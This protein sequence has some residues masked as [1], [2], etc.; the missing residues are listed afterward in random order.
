ME[1]ILK[2]ISYGHGITSSIVPTCSCGWVGHSEYAHND[3]QFT[4]LREQEEKHIENSERD[5]VPDWVAEEK[6]AMARDD[7]AYE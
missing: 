1:H 3:Y 4:N 7:A 2:R 6:L 5:E